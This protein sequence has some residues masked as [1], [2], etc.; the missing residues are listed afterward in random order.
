MSSDIKRID[1]SGGSEVK[2]IECDVEEVRFERKPRQFE[3]D[4]YVMINDEILNNLPEDGN[5]WVRYIKPDGKIVSGGYL[6]KNAFPSYLILMNPNTSARFSVG[7]DK[8]NRFMVTKKAL[9]RIKK[10]IL[11]EELWND[12]RGK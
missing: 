7:C 1:T 10:S 4:K 2:Q 8:G 9:P 3:A 5:T 12:F 11:K 6:V